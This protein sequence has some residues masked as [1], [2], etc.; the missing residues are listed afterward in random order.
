[1]MQGV[2]KNFPSCEIQ[3]GVAKVKRFMIK[4]EEAEMYNIRTLMSYGNAIERVDAGEF[5]KLY[6]NGVLMMSDTR[7]E[8]LTN[9]DLIK[10]VHGEVMIA[11]LGIGLIL[12]NI[13]PLY[14]EGKIT[15]VVVYEKY[16]DVI[17]LVAHRYLNRLPLEVRCEDILEYKPKKE[18]KYD[19]LYFDIWPNIST[20]NLEQIKLLHNRW[21]MHKKEG[22]WMNSWMAEFLRKRR[23]EERRE[24]RRYHW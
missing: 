9:Y 24:E 8:R 13:I 14:K 18:E 17:D 21:K 11:G 16:K 6:V 5:V 22:S 3:L 20:D 1:M 23:R 10:N 15:K 19:T 7:M 4:E 12:E 2:A